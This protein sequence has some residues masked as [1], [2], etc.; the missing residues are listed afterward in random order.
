MSIY[1]VTFAEYDLFADAT[2]HDKPDDRGWGRGNQ[3]V[4]DISWLDAVA[5]TEWLSKQTGQIYRLPTEAEWEYAARG[6]E[7]TAYWWGN[8]IGQNNAAC[9]GCGSQWD[10]K[11]TAPVGSFSANK[12]GLYDVHG[13]VWEWTCS[14]YVEHYNGTE[15][16][17]ES[18][19]D[20]VRVLRGGA[21]NSSPNILRSALRIR[22][23]VDDAYHTF[24]FRVV[25]VF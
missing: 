17:C 12:Y 23:N 8:E 15:N 7:S 14:F 11:Q 5:Y 2:A 13:N 3:P 10:N 9:N 6:G 20:G 1:E 25:R 16:Y 21:W 22:H 19:N 18:N 4:I 24:G